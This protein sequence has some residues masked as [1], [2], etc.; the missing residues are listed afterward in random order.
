MQASKHLS[1]EQI[2]ALSLMIV[3]G[4]KMEN[5]WNPKSFVFIGKDIVHLC[6]NKKHFMVRVTINSKKF[7]N[8]AIFR[9][10]NPYN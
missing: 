1:T 6:L 4:Q 7:Q 8:Y 9:S 3:T 5:I 2:T 10:T